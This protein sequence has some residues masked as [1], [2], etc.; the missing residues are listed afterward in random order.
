M[1]Q[2]KCRRKGVL[3]YPLLD[4]QKTGQMPKLLFQV[5][6]VSCKSAVSAIPVSHF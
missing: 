3:H 1:P 4:F 5:C 6:S 2:T